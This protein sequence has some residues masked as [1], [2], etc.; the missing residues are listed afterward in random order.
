MVLY[1]IFSLKLIAAIAIVVIV[2][3]IIDVVLQYTV[4]LFLRRSNVQIVIY[5]IL[6][7]PVFIY[8]YG[9]IGAGFHCLIDTYKILGAEPWIVYTL[10]IVALVFMNNGHMRGLQRTGAKAQF[11]EEEYVSEEDKREA[12]RHIAT[13]A[14]KSVG[15]VAPLS[16]I[17]FFFTSEFYVD[18]YFGLPK[19]YS[20]LFL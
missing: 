9:A 6:V 1:V 11:P 17:V 7:S 20:E 8:A 13:F 14:S 2:A 5:C 16:F 10:A 12:Y 19:W 18:F 15:F 4:G 3:T